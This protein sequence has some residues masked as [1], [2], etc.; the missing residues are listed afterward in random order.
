V[1][2]EF[3]QRSI[4]LAKVESRPSK[5]SLGRYIFLVDLE[6]HREDIVINEALARVREKAALF[7]ILGSYPRYEEK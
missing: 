6:G 4:N 3:A 5:E 2:Q 7:K 1:L